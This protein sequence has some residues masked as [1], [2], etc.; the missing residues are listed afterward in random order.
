MMLSHGTYGKVAA[1]LDGACCK[2]TDVFDADSSIAACNLTEAV[3]SAT[4][5][6]LR[7][8][9]EPYSVTFNASR[10]HFVITMARGAKDL[11]HYVQDTP[12]REL[13]RDALAFVMDMVVGLHSLHEHGYA[14]CDVKP[15]NIIVMDNKELR[16]CDFGSVRHTKRHGVGDTVLCTLETRAPET[17]LQGPSVPTTACDAYSLGA[18]IFF[19][20]YNGYL[21]DNCKHTTE[22]Q[23][24]QV[25]KDCV[26]V[27]P[28]KCPHDLP[29]EVFGIMLGLL[30]PDPTQ[31][32]TISELYYRWNDEG[33]EAQPVILDPFPTMASGSARCDAIDTLYALNTEK[34]HF[35]L[36]V[37]IMDRY[38]CTLGRPLNTEEV[39][40]CAVLAVVTLSPDDVII[41]LLTLT[42]TMVVDIIRVLKF[43]LYADTCD[44]LLL[45]V[46]RHPSLDYPLLRDLL[47]QSGCTQEVVLLY[48][49][50]KK[51]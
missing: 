6:N 46:Y 15:S 22:K 49:G 34:R 33:I 41:P 24:G 48:L 10:S 27:L 23:V 51:I 20:V 2:R 9:I 28:D 47:K 43:Q 38:A 14:H 1:T 8:T 35:G 50:A 4:P 11:H 18:T 37:N 26:I 13:R 36:S 3:F 7:N 12:C 30:N 21:Y 17:F 45:N 42:R 16:L 25:H 40:A 31:R 44:W 39:Y 29:E 19:L 5:R 32:T